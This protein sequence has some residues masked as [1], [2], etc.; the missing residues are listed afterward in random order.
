MTAKAK[1]IEIKK[2][3]MLQGLVQ[4]IKENRDEETLMLFHKII[5]LLDIGD[6]DSNA[7]FFFAYDNITG[8]ITND[9]DETLVY[10]KG[11]LQLV[12]Q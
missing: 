5:G 6:F 3:R 8:I 1:M 9:D 11:D 12:V 4:Q 10:Y 2:N 7:E